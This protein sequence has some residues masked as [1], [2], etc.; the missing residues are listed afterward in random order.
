MICSSTVPSTV[1]LVYIA[2]CF[3]SSCAL[4]VFAGKTTLLR[5]VV[6]L[7][8]DKFKKRTIVVDTS[9]EIG[10]DGD[11]PHPCLGSARRMSPVHR[12]KQHEVI[13]EA[14]QNHTPE[15]TL[16]GVHPRLFV[17]CTAFWSR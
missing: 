9:N 7:L 2:Q 13:L 4:E 5:D 8:A 3:G 14:V 16:H 1:L 10:G 12:S 6:R 11:V 17:D 15:V